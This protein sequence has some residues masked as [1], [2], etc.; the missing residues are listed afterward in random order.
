MAGQIFRDLG[1][2]SE[3]RKEVDIRLPVAY[4]DTIWSGQGL[5]DRFP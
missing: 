4:L 5:R 3:T 2:A 1:K